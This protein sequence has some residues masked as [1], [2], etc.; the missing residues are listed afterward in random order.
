M[1]DFK[2]FEKVAEDDKTTT[3]RH[4][5][6]HEIRVILKGLRPIEREQI[7]RLKLAEGGK[8]QKFADKGLVEDQGDDAAN[9]SE[10]PNSSIAPTAP[11]VAPA[12]TQSLQT[13]QPAKINVPQV[14]A[15]PNVL[16]PDGTMNPGAVAQTGQA[17]IDLG[18]KVEAEAAKAKA[19]YDQEYNNEAQRLKNLEQQHY[20]EFA[21][22]AQETTD[23]MKAG[24]INPSQYGQSQTDQQ[25]MDTGIGLFL[26]GMGGQGHSNMALDFLNKQID[27]NIDAQKENFEHQKTIY[28][29]YKDLYGNQNIATNLAKVA[30]NDLLVHKV[31]MTAAQLGTPAAA[32]KAMQLK[33]AK[34]LENSKLMQDSAV[35]VKVLP[36][37]GG[38]TLG[39]IGQPMGG[40]TATNAKT[41]AEK[42]P[43]SIL[44]PHAEQRFKD[45]AYT[46]K[47]KENYA[48]IQHQYNNAVQADKALAQIDDT[49]VKLKKNVDE[50]SIGGN[51]RRRGGHAVAGLPLGIGQAISGSLNYLTDTDA[52]KA[53]DSNQSNLL[54]YIS[55][56]LKG[57]NVGGEQI[58]DIVEKNSPERGDPPE[59]LEQKKQTIKDFIKNHTDTSLLSAWKL[60]R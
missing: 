51:L 57:T 29:A 55:S 36:G 50:G 59:L 22:H 31:D 6:G 46:P 38:S 15:T 48:A 32:A 52:N 21:K 27:R 43:D 10:A 20:Q 13:A 16:N 14:P 60:T 5:K 33:S 18:Q 17:G 2:N 42:T 49:F 11:A 47:A 58:Q 28:G 24:V 37:G 26:G 12:P 4:P 34:A 53:Y 3:L 19:Q 23:A 44:G 8:V 54:G 7:K 1:L 45:L 9:S 30:A 56:A 25:R 41:S 40:T 35:D 39:G